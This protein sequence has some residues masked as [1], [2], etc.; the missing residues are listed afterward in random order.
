MSKPD[1]L[2]T[3]VRD[4]APRPSEEFLESLDAR[5]AERFGKPERE[6]RPRIA[7]WP[8]WRIARRGAPPGRRGRLG[9]GGGGGAG[10]AGWRKGA[11]AA[12]A[13]R[14]PRARPPRGRRRRR[15]TK[16]FAPPAPPR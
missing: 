6:R 8:K 1:D 4:A 9:P 16:R 14:T 15:P 2:A 7:A 13:P 11:G 10:W 12:A 3:L 5:V